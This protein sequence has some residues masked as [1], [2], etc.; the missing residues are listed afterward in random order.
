MLNILY[1]KVELK[2]NSPLPSDC[3]LPHTFILRMCSF[4]IRWTVAQLYCWWPLDISKTLEWFGVMERH[5]AA[6]AAVSK[7]PTLQT[8]SSTQLFELHHIWSWS[9][10]AVFGWIWTAKKSL[11]YW[12]KTYHPGHTPFTSNASYF[13][14][15]KVGR[16]TWQDID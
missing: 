14:L 12:H 3:I 7:N 13:N 16:C 15:I 1:F 2:H 4:F 11:Q 10:V 8:D 6:H 9:S 5:T